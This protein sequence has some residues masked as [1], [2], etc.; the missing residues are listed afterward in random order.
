MVKRKQT[1]T[2]YVPEGCTC[3][4][5]DQIKQSTNRSILSRRASRP[6][7]K[8]KETWCRFC[9]KENNGFTCLASNSRLSVDIEGNPYKDKACVNRRNIPADATVSSNE[10][11]DSVETEVAP[12]DPKLMMEWTIKE[13]NKY[14]SEYQRQGYPADL[15]YKMAQAMVLG[16]DSI[17]I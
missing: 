14:Y 1:L 5:V 15:S 4:Q 12:V 2:F 10:P 13:F 6:R 17:K 11:N 9:K 16:E 3:N 7:Y 8:A